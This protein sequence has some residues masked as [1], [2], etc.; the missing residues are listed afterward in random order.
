MSFGGR[1]HAVLSTAQTKRV[2][3]TKTIFSTINLDLTS[4]QM[5]LHTF[6]FFSSHVYLQPVEGA[7]CLHRVEVTC[8]CLAC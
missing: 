2:Q 8:L 5:G 4:L 6:S 7:V 3:T 1:I